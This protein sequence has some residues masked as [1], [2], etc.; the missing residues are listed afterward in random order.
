MCTIGMIPAT[1]SVTKS[2]P[3]STLNFGLSN[4]DQNVDANTNE[5][6]NHW[7]II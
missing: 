4:F 2:P 6:K 7:P 3:L 1:P 5:H